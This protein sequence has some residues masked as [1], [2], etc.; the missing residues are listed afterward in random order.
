MIT[1]DLEN[2]LSERVRHDYPEYPVYIRHGLLSY[3]PNHAAP[4]HWH[5][6]VE[7]IAVQSGQMDYNVNGQILT[8]QQ[9]TGFSSTRAKCIMVFP[10]HSRNASFFVFC[11]I[12][13]RSAF[14]LFWNA[15]SSRRSP[16]TGAFLLRY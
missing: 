1:M 11:S 3:Y 2:D 8:L 14:P 9:E 5:D 7:F 10:P 15:R 16:K 12:R 6:D 4:S 13:R